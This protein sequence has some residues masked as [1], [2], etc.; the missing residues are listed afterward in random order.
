M[1]NEAPQ[2][3]NAVVPGQI[4]TRQEFGRELTRLR[5][6]AGLTVRAV[7]N[8]LGIPASTVGDYFGGSH[9]PPVKPPDLMRRLLH[10]CGVQDQDLVEEWLEALSRVRRAP[11]QRPSSGPVPYRGLAAFQPEDAAWFHGREKLTSAMVRQLN[12]R[13][14][15]GGLLVAVGASGSGKSSLLRAGLIPALRSGAPG[16]PGSEE[17]P[18]V[19]LTPGSRPMDTLAAELAQLRLDRAGNDDSKPPPGG[20]VI[21]VDQFEEVFTACAEEAERQSFITALCE[22]A[23]GDR[24]TLAGAP[25]LVVLGLRADF[26]PHALACAALVPALQDGQILIGPMTEDELRSV[27][28]KPAHRAG[29]DV[30]DGLVEVLLRDLLP[31]EGGPAAA[32]D[33]GVLPLLSH[34][35]LI[36]YQ[37]SR[38]RRLTVADYRG[39]GGIRGAVACSAEEAFGELTERQQGVAR[40]IFI[41]MVHVADDTADTRRRVL[42]SELPLGQDDAQ[43]VLD[44]FIRQRLI[45]AEADGIQIT[46]EALLTAWPRLRD[47][48][49]ADR[50]GLATH[51]QL[52]I[53]AELWQRSGRDANALYRGGRLDAARD[54][55]AD[56]P[57]DD[58]LNALENDFLRASIAHQAAEERA[59]RRS[60]LRL[61]QLVAG[62]T[63]LIVVAAGLAGL[64]FEQK[65]AA[66]RQRNV[67]ISQ[68]VA[69][70]A[71]QLRSTDVNLAMQLSLAAY[72]VDP[73][74]QAR[75][76]LLES[77]A[78]PAV[79][80]LIGLPGL[81]QAVAVA[82]GG[83]LMA[84]AG[85]YTRIRVWSL[86]DPGRPVTVGRP[87]AGHHGPVYALAFSPSGRILASGSGDDTVRLWNTASPHRIIPD[88]PALTGPANTVYSVAFGPDGKLL[89]AGSAD[90]RVWLWNLADPRHPVSFGPRAEGPRGY[91][92]AV[93]F[94][95]DGRYLAAGRGDGTV[96]L[97]DLSRPGHPAPTGPPLRA[98]ARAVLS[99]AFSPDG[100]RVAAGGQDDQVR[101]WNVADPRHPRR[102]GPPLTGPTSYVNSVAF[103]PDGRTLAAG[104]SDSDVRIWDLATGK[105]IQTLPHPAPVTDVVFVPGSSDTLATAATD[106]IA[107]LWRLPG[108]VISDP[109][110]SLSAQDRQIFSMAFGRR[111]ELAV[112]TVGN[113]ARL[114]QTADPRHPVPLGP[115]IRDASRSAQA[116]GAD[117]LSPDG[118]TLA[119]GA[120]DG[121]IQLWNVSDP[122]KPQ[123]MAPLH[124]PGQDVQS[125]SFSSD[126]TLLAAGSN[127]TRVWLWKMTDPAHPVPLGSLPTG[128]KNIVYSPVFSPDNRILAASGVDKLVRLWD[129]SRPARTVPLTRPLAGATGYINSVAF[130]PDGR[131]L[132]AG[133]ADD[134]VRLWDITNPRR[135]VPLGQ[136]LRGPANYVDSVAFSSDGRTLAATD[137]DGSIWLWDVSA[138]PQLRAALTGSDA[139]IFTGNYDPDRSILATGGADGMVRLWDTST[140]QVAAFVCSVAGDPIT[141]SEWRTYI[142]GLPYQPPCPEPAPAQP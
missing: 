24:A 11:G 65:R 73:T 92:Q 57:H 136:P 116:S 80:R 118:R 114:W 112:A 125:M 61:R 87:L 82:R 51:R 115:V 45:T 35:L 117:A 42:S 32:A 10:A 25:A 130:S 31:T 89:A 119:I 104:S 99:V 8:N 105:V 7:A 2:A 135:P 131:I 13:Q 107:R 36:T 43:Q 30:E 132:A 68:K 110:G 49:D 88:G 140:S 97:W 109:A 50:V 52:T 102:D 26:Y 134:L 20:L 71:N 83:Q 126:G 59:A 113:T 90:G 44:V 40:Q 120:H 28:V 142:P 37:R 34:A 4:S 29:L 111:H 96:Q 108:P 84:A 9:L 23:S 123:A 46:H 22:L 74:A 122:A 141:R 5:E 124:G 70:D 95:P 138:R 12:E 14:L 62:L 72:Q 41:R 127:D 139:S 58:D 129:V 17:W 6:R 101:L 66:T 53:A 86:K 75:A 94:S 39:S 128:P 85:D 33:N 137:N 54:W 56:S 98:S 67:A 121:T 103:S 47:W 16:V 106:G 79:T 78:G 1:L 93:A 81:M 19:I 27:I 64:V 15:S 133:G 60:A 3:A 55:A 21:I 100:Q 63:V 69:A 38:R 77:W 76:S 91:V 48:I 18:V